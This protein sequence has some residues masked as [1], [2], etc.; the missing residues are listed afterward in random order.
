MT[1]RP[2]AVLALL[3]F[4]LPLAAAPARAQSWA[5]FDVPDSALAGA[6]RAS[7][8][9]YEAAW[10]ALLVAQLRA[11]PAHADSAK[12]RLALAR[13]VAGA[14]PEALGSHI[15][16]DALA[17]RVTWSA[18]QKRE[19]VAAAVAESIGVAA[20]GARRFDLADSA[21]TAALDRYRALGEKRRTAW[22][23]GT[24]GQA[25]F[26][27]SRYERADSLYRL[28]LAA[29][30]ELPD[31]RM[32]GASL[33]ALG[34][35]NYVLGRY[36]EARN[37]FEGARAIREQTGERAALGQTWN[38]LGVILNEL[39][40]PD[41]AHIAYLRALELTVAQGD[42]ARAL[43][44]MTNL[45][46]LLAAQGDLAAAAPLRARAMALAR[47]RGNDYYARIMFFNEGRGLA[48]QGRFSEARA[49]FDTALALTL[50]AGDRRARAE[51]LNEMGRLGLRIADPER[52]RGPLEAAKAAADSLGIGPLR[53]GVRNNLAVAS[54]LEGDPAGGEPA[55]REALEISFTDG[56][57]LRVRESVVTL[58]QLAQA[59]GDARTARDWF[60]RALAI[61]ASLGL[62]TEAAD[63]NNVAVA[64]IQAGDT[65]GAEP[66]CRRALALCETS[67]QPEVRAVALLNLS[68]IAERRKN[69]SLAVRHGRAAA[70]LIDTLRARQRSERDAIAVAS[71]RRFAQDALIH[72]LLKL[73][74]QFPDSGYAAEAFHW[75][76][77][78]RARSLLDIVADGSGAAAQPLTLE[79]ARAQV[80]RDGRAFLE[81]SVGDSSTALWVITA[82][83]TNHYRLP[84]RRALQPRI[85]QLRRALADPGRAGSRSAVQAS[86][87][88]YTM[89]IEPAAVPLAKA[90]R[91]VI[92]SDGPL[93]LIPF[94]ALLTKD[95]GENR[96]PAPADWLGSR[97]AIAYAFSATTW[98]ARRE[99]AAPGVGVVA[100]GNPDF[101][102]GPPALAPLPNTALE[103]ESLR[104]L[105]GRQPFT[106]LAGAAATRAALL[107]QPALPTSRLVHVATHGVADVNEPA[108]SGLFLAPASVGGPPGFLS[109]GD[110]SGL[111]LDAT[112][113]TLSACETGL[114]QLARG[115]G[116]IG[117]PRA[118]AAAGARGVMVSLWRVNDAS[119]A[120]L[121]RTFYTSWMKKGESADL[122][123]AH[124]RRQ[125]MKSP[126]TRSPHH[127]APFVLTGDAGPWK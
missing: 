49:S 1:R 41:S 9:Q 32:T 83:G 22:L 5:R 25:A 57:S 106:E 65:A 13:R 30:R 17:L 99:S 38:F 47:A 127:W 53:S 120:A 14:E 89:L 108:R 105:A 2:P 92:S 19:R 75:A 51:V 82:R 46:G 27:S 104:T 109:L 37:F 113:V 18:A 28:A 115:E 71:G 116:V 100:V 77:R 31:A 67:P 102:P 98:S 85:E 68:D 112:L 97:V 95:P 114:G 86:S 61:S 6:L 12:R 118:F 94:E 72:L 124:A 29:R 88:L 21:L 73:D 119:T 3:L 91:L 56:D 90:T 11:E 45:H 8:G 50:A 79:Q 69:W 111:R 70:T 60:V 62:N 24:L 54:R 74:A 64:M 63:L 107:A 15:A 7:G 52:A 76:E 103:L 126:G 84:S 16:P 101:G 122:A 10:N 121:M 110:I 123:L 96:E 23:Y 93:A 20:Q 35:T 78:A 33:N 39:G 80:T 43:E 40:K 44:V 48:Q 4:V 26:Q 36:A 58:G 34:S 81:Y 117:L 55:A 42:S 66:L 59:R 87:A 125:L